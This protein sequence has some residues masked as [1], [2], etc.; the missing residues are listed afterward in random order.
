MSSYAKQSKPESTPIS[1]YKYCGKGGLLITWAHSRI[2]KQVSCLHVQKNV[3]LGYHEFCFA[4]ITSRD[5][6]L[7]LDSR[8]GR[9]E[10]VYKAGMSAGLSVQSRDDQSF[11]HWQDICVFCHC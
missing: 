11:R 10:E 7:S 1:D 4:R 6:S 3:L 9:Q 5:S 8:Q 2:G